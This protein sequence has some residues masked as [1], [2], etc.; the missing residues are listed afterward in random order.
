MQ[1]E[2][3]PRKSLLWGR[4][5]AGKSAILKSVF[6]AFD[7]EPHG[8]L[9]NWDYSAIL[10]VDFTVGS[11]ELTTV[12]REDLR[13]LFEGGRLIGVATNSSKW[14]EIFAA[15]VGFD[16]RLLD[17]TGR[18]RHAAPSNF[19]L[20]F[21]INQDGSFGANW[22]TFSS[23]KQFQRPVEHTLEYF[24]RVRPARYFELKAD[25]Q[26][27]KAKNSVL[28]VELAT[29][30]RTRIRLRRNTKITPVKLSAKDFHSEVKELTARSI[31]LARKQDGLRKNI[32]EDQELVFSLSEQIRLSNAALKEH[33]ADFKF[34]AEVSAKDHKFVC[35]T[36]NAMHDD[37]FHT[38]LGLAEDARELTSLKTSLERRLESIRLRLDRNRRMALE[39]RQQYGAIQDLL[40]VKRGKFTFDDFIKSYNANTADAQLAAEEKCVVNEVE[41][42]A[43]LLSGIKFELKV[44]GVAHDSKAPLERFRNCFA[45]AIVELDVDKPDGLEKWGLSKRPFNSGSRYA[46]S[47]IAYYAALW[48]TIAQDGY[49]PAPVVIDSPNQGAQDKE[50][51][52]ELLAVLAAT[53]PAHTQVI[54][55]HEELPDSFDAD[56]VVNL[57]KEERLL[58][59]EGFKEVSPELF[60]F[61]ED[62]RAAVAGIFYESDNEDSNSSEFPDY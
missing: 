28:K 10:A 17:R 13:A 26:E 54:L 46:R 9:P 18:F 20:P 56:K 39:L 43:G 25:E 12:R 49:L 21:F 55:A 40:N 42:V 51:L 29:L 59:H 53:A 30:S 32:V 50:H 8:T 6:R 44:L 22:D 16:L 34:A 57:R 19:F 45:Q 3:H 7:A 14:N 31:D 23:L 48:R 37:S 47:I 61:V 15:V 41:V 4:N 1:L 5:G 33:A 11:R 24:A 52:Q 2:F 38:F 60:R 58:T 27:K 36:C 35:P 62:A